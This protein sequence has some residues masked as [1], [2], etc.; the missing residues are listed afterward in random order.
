MLVVLIAGAAANAVAP[1]MLWAQAAEV[2]DKI[3]AAAS[4]APVDA[5]KIPPLIRPPTAQEQM[6][7]SEWARLATVAE[8]ARDWPEVERM[9]RQ[10]IAIEERTYGPSHPEVAGSQSQ[11]AASYEARALY[12]EAE[13]LLRKSLVTWRAVLGEKHP[14]TATGYNNLAYNLHAQGRFV[15]AQPLYEEALDVLKAVFGDQHQLTASSYNNVAANLRAQGRYVEAEPLI[16]KAIEIKQSLLGEQHPGTAISYTWLAYSLGGQGRYAEAEPLLRKS[17]EIYQTVLGERDPDTGLGYANLAMNLG[18]QGRYADA[19]PLLRTALEISQ[20]VLGEQHPVTATNYRN[21]AYNL[22]KQGRHV[23]AAPLIRKALEI[24]REVLGE[25]HPDTAVSYVN[26]ASNIYAQG[27]YAEGEALYRKALEV[28]QAALGE[29]HPITALG[30][31]NVAA[32]L[33]AQGRYAEAEPL[34]SKAV[35]ISR[36]IRVRESSSSNPGAGAVSAQATDADA[37]TTYLFTS[38]SLGGAEASKLAQLRSAAFTVAQ[39]LE[40]SSAGQALAQAAARVA[41]G[42]AGLS[43]VVRKRQDLAVQARGY[44]ARLL[45]ALGAGDQA[46]AQAMRAELARSSQE[47]SGLD[48]EIR[49]KFPRYAELVSPQALEVAEVQE[50]LK[51]GEGVLLIAPSGKDVH[52]F[53]V[54]KTKVAWNRVEGGAKGVAEAVSVL[55]CQADPVTCQQGGGATRGAASAYGTALSQGAKPFDRAKAYGLHRD[56]IAPVEDALEGVTTLY[57][58]A[59]G[60]LSGLPLGLLLTQAP[61]GGDDADPQALAASPWL[62][63]RYALVTL[64]SVSSLR[65]LGALKTAPGRLALAGYGD[66]VLDGKPGGAR[67]ANLSLF[68]CVSPDGHPLADLAALRSTLAPVPG[69]RVELEAMAAALN[70]PR[71]SLRLGSAATEASVKTSAELS[72]AQVVVFAT[73]GLLPHELKGLEE[74]G[75]VFTPPATATAD[76][77]GV[78]TAS[79]AARLNL[80]ADWV[81]LSACNTASADGTPGGESLS[82]LAKA[83]LYAG[84]NALMASHWRVQDDVT[85]ALTV[86]TISLQRSNP[87]LSKAQALQAAMKAVRTGTLPDGSPLPGWT[88]AWSH[89]AAWAPFS[90][91]TAGG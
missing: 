74:P 19:D 46:T 69:T 4:E 26:F 14:D 76:D 9:F 30:Y 84:A 77:D 54:S 43:D 37:F 59:S 55:R 28:F 36:A 29:Q 21:L 11:I 73:H 18:A 32:N 3:Q 70:M 86:Q 88:P 15:E 90:L 53:A 17:L 16:R 10:I 6:H 61:R 51:P 79:E 87:G 38:W 47:L 33:T 49:T 31:N 75:L 80:S 68:R 44:D 52:V 60:P 39:D 64:P 67:S 56:L 27:R 7:V 5:T 58:T 71:T 23:E 20:A 85:A 25:R 50:R 35:E 72:Q 22:D 48:D 12:A 1:A 34:A 57:V 89:P 13:P 40:A 41:A 78:L 63:D 82:G 66:P 83:F 81:I 65:A 62:A 8:K 45:Q 2:E 42:Q 91:I 24:Q